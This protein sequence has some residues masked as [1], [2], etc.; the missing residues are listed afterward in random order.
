M[1]D[2]PFFGTAGNP[3]SF[4]DAGFEDILDA[5]KYLE[6]V[7]LTAYE[8]QGGHGVRISDARAKNL[9]KNAKEHNIKLSIHSPYYISVSSTDEEI[10]EKSIGYIL[11][12]AKAAKAMGAE[13]IVV[14]SG[15]CAKMSRE[16]ALGLAKDTFKRAIAAMDELGFEDIHLCP[17]TMGKINQLGTVDEVMEICSIDERLIPCIDFGHVYAR[18]L[19]GLASL[20]DYEYIFKAIKDKLGCERVKCFHSHFSHIEYSEGGEKRHLTFADG[21]FGPEFAP[22][23]EMCLRYSS[24]PTF[25]CESRGTQAVDALEMKKTYL[26]VKMSQGEKS[27]VKTQNSRNSR[28]E[29]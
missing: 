11:T 1:S 12:C 28:T 4:Y 25:I 19:G 3:D 14:H 15:S 27:H 2:I 24:T 13:R 8:Y 21:M 26:D 10:R 6:S 7:G 20:P 23:A 17:E 18:S 22:V 5:P 29:S 16:E 9:G